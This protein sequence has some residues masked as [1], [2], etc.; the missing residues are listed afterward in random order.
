MGFVKRLGL[1]GALAVSGMAYSSCA[2]LGAVFERSDNPLVSLMGTGMRVFG[3]HQYRME[4]AKAGKTEV[5]VVSK[6]PAKLEES[7]PVVVE[8]YRNK[9]EKNLL[10]EVLKGEKKDCVL[11]VKKWIDLDGDGRVSG[12]EL[13]DVTGPVNV[14]GFGLGF[15]YYSSFNSP[16]KLSIFDSSGKKLYEA[17]G[18]VSDGKGLVS[19]DKGGSFEY[20]GKKVELKDGI[21]KAV[22]EEGNRLVFNYFEVLRQNE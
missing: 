2:P 11:E 5:T 1:V 21:Y 9:F 22:V 4:E 18:R 10:G 7:P 16:F 3:S 17:M 14:S 19:L 20:R 8:P 15:C 13:Y 12:R 6:A